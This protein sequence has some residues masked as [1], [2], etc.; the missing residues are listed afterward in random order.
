MTSKVVYGLWCK[1]AIADIKPMGYFETWC[2]FFLKLN[3]PYLE[4]LEEKEGGDYCAFSPQGIRSGI[5][6]NSPAF[7]HSKI[8]FILYT[9]LLQ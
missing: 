9:E 7:G 4:A 3:V 6:I 1:Y 2:N 5:K 8:C